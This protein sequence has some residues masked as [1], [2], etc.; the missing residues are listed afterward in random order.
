MTV[1]DNVAFGLE[2]DGLPKREHLLR[3]PARR[4]IRALLGKA[5]NRVQRLS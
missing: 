1:L 5:V 2:M 3:I 4:L